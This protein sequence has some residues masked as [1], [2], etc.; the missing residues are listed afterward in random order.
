MNGE[1]F[2]ILST[3]DTYTT[4]VSDDYDTNR[5]IAVWS[6]SPTLPEIMNHNITV[7]NG[8]ISN[9]ESEYVSDIR[10]A[11]GNYVR[12]MQ[13]PTSALKVQSWVVTDTCLLYTSSN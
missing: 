2:T 13:D 12:V 6:D 1:Q 9:E 3:E 5:I 10:V 4:T 8:F 7:V 11:D